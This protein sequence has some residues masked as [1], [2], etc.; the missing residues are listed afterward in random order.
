MDSIPY[1]RIPAPW[2]IDYSKWMPLTPL[3]H[4]AQLATYAADHTAE[5]LTMSAEEWVDP[6]RTQPA[7][8]D[9]ILYLRYQ[10]ERTRREQERLLPDHPAPGYH[11]PMH[12]K[13]RYIRS[14]SSFAELV[15]HKRALRYT[16]RPTPEE[17]R[18]Q[19]DEQRRIEQE[20]A[21]AKAKAQ[22]SERAAAEQH[23]RRNIKRWAKQG[24]SKNEMAR[25]LGGRKSTVYALID[26]VLTR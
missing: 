20:Q 18:A 5:L 2:N 23:A 15:Q 13:R 7:Y 10:T 19:W 25:R 9:P 12:Y 17:R 4:F 8:L 26:A 6:L 21:A 1:Q 22:A 14:P 11:S 16:P 24:L 3:A